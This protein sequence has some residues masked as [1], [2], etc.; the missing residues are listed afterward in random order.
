MAWST[1]FTAVSNSTYTAAQHN[2][3]VR[4]NLLETFPA[5]ATA[6]GQIA[7]STGANAI[8]ARTPAG[9]RVDAS[10]ST[11][12]TS[13]TALTTA[14][15]V[16]TATTG[17]A[18]IV[19]FSA[20]MTNSSAGAAC[21]AYVNVTGASSVSLGDAGSITHEPGAAAVDTTCSRTI[22]YT[23]TG[24]SN[25]FTMLYRASAGT[26]TFLRRTLVVIPL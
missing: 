17:G 1:P 3:S 8:A 21:L 22:F 10:E 11:T 19:L 4:D 15:P 16:L 24:G 20:Q 14:G 12:S 23:L 2:A 7:V 26:A 13:Y 18:A 9:D 5:K 25:T 6:A